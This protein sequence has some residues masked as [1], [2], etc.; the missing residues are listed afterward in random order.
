MKHL[1]NSILSLLGSTLAILFCI[2]CSSEKKTSVSSQPSFHDTLI[3]GLLPTLDCLP[4]YVAREEGIFDSMR[5]QVRFVFAHSQMDMDEYLAKGYVEIGATDILRTIGMQYKKRNIRYLAS[6]SRE[7]EVYACRKYRISQPWQLGDRMLGSTRHSVPDFIS[8]TLS[9]LVNQ[10]KRQ[11]LRP[12]INDVFLRMRMLDDGQ[13]EAAIL[14]VPLTLA[15]QAKK[16]TPIY[17]SS[18]TKG[19]AGFA[20]STRQ[21]SL[22]HI[23]QVIHAYNMAVNSL[24]KHP[25]RPLPQ[26]FLRYLRTDSLP[27]SLLTDKHLSHLY[28]PDDRTIRQA[29]T[30]ALRQKVAGNS[31]TTDTLLYSKTL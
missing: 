19:L 26:R 24:K 17:N 1:R 13:L 22:T 10:K 4:F 16:H 18:C 31:Y 23:R 15:M 25:N 3:I 2:A 14:P 7:W 21:T 20:V 28:I 11:L 30:W 6:S 27:V 8:D 29:H 9:Q 5:L 12:Q